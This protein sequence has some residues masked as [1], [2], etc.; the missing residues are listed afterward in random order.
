MKWSGS[1][2]FN[3]ATTKEWRVKGQV[4]GTFKTFQNLT[5]LKVANSG[6]VKRKFIPF[7]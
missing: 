7:Y 1:N 5:F 4:A 6:H 2:G 3:N